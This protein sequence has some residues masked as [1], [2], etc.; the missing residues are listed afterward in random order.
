MFLTFKSE[1]KAFETITQKVIGSCL[2][3]HDP[4]ALMGKNYYNH[5]FFLKYKFKKNHKTIPLL[6]PSSFTLSSQQSF[7]S[8]QLARKTHKNNL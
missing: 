3:P 2:I 8:I 4:S 7:T 6:S 1:W 5:P